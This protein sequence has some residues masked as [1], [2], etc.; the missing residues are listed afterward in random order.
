MEFDIIIPYHAKDCK[1]VGD[2]ISSCR[3]FIKGARNIYVVTND[4]FELPDIHGVYVLKQNDFFE[5]DITISYI[6]ELWKKEN[7]DLAHRAGWIFQQFVKMGACYRIPGISDNYIAVDSDLVFLKPM[8]FIKENG[9]IKMFKGVSVHP[10]YLTCLEKLLN[11]SVSLPS[12]SYVL[13]MMMFDKKIMKEM[14]DRIEEVHSKSWYDAVLA[15]IDFYEP[16]PFSEFQTYGEYVFLKY[17][18]LY[19]LEEPDGIDLDK[20][21]N[22]V[23]QYEGKADYLLFSN[24]IIEREKKKRIRNLFRIRFWKKLL[25]FSN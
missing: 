6:N 5:N 11:I 20:Y 19:Y 22:D 16:S 14:L 7:I 4:S 24:F 13:H 3:K 15:T 9:Q 8:E 10:P 18:E 1:V 25:K 12:T 21:I 23:T 2:C 17:P